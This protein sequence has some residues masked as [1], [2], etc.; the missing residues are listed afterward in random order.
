[1]TETIQCAR[2]VGCAIYGPDAQLWRSP[3][4]DLDWF[5][6]MVVFS[7]APAIYGG[8]DQIQRNIVGERGLGL[9]KEP[10]HPRNTPFKDLPANATR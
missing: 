5:Q 1:M 8:T 4:E 2:D 6:E 9:P 10:G 3:D 7:P